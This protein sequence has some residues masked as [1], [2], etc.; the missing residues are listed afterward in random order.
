MAKIEIRWRAHRRSSVGGQLALCCSRASLP[1]RRL[2]GACGSPA[3]DAVT[4][5]RRGELARPGMQGLE[6]PSHAT[7][8][9]ADL[10]EATGCGCPRS[11]WIAASA[12]GNTR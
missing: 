3:G 4:A 10:S 5:D 7:V 8:R 2:S 11:L 9:R 6:L 1:P 12:S